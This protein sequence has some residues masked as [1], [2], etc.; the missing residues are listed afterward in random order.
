MV[1]PVNDFAAIDA[2]PNANDMVERLPQVNE[3]IAGKMTHVTYRLLS[4]LGDG[5][6]GTVF[7]ATDGVRKVAVKT[8]KF[9]RSMLHV[10]AHV[11]RTATRTRCNRIA[12]LIDYGDVPNNYCF[13]VMPLLGK[14]LHQLRNEQRERRFSHPTSLRIGIMSLQAIQE[15]HEKCGFLSRD[16]KSGNFA[17]GLAARERDIF[18]IDFGLARKYLDRNRNVL[19]SRGE[20]GWRGTTRYGSLNAHLKLDLGRKDD[21]ESWFYMMVELTKGA[22]PWRQM[23]DRSQVHAAKLSART[24]TRVQFLSECPVEFDVI[25]THIDSLAFVD[26]P[27]YKMII[28]LLEESMRN[29]GATWQQ[30]YDWEDEITHSTTSLSSE[31][32]AVQS[33]AAVNVVNRADRPV[34]ETLI[35]Q[36]PL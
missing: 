8:E 14:D 12:E 31:R 1:N 28:S 27:N 17:V 22:V 23:T 13:L 16:I 15:L 6:Y 3:T 2:D 5:G 19:P 33:N 21:V 34:P 4:V 32:P 25:L 7:E 9:S 35:P 30:L 29:S 36:R 20:I 26:A 11:L 10:E 18:L 24:N